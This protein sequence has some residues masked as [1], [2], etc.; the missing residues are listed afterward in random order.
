MK[1]STR[2]RT[3]GIFHEVRGTVKEVAGKI[4]SNRMLGIKGRF[5]RLTG[6]FQWK[7]GTAQGFFGF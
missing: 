4:S 2:Y 6:K 1:L 5:E 3:K 7:I